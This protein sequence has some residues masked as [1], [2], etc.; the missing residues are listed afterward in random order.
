MQ[1]S[2]GVVQRK[3]EL[4]AALMRYRPSRLLGEPEEARDGVSMAR[5]QSQGGQETVAKD[6]R[7]VAL[8]LLLADP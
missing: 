4:I 5:N 2:E 6:R 1:Q 7:S 3:T 8:H